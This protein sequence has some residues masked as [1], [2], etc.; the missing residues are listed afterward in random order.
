[1]APA[2]EFVSALHVGKK[3]P[4]GIGDLVALEIAKYLNLDVSDTNWVTPTV[5]NVTDLTE[6]SSLGG[7]SSSHWTLQGWVLDAASMEALAEEFPDA[8]RE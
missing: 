8:F 1:M 4:E 2:H 5:R 6:Q 3:L 7:F